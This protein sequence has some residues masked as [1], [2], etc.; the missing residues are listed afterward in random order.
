MLPLGLSFFGLSSEVKQYILDEFY[1]L[2]KFGGFS[3]SDLMVMP[4]YERKF[5]MNKL[6]KEYE[7]KNE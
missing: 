4:V 6:T 3:Y 2:V 5:F 7:K 1:Y